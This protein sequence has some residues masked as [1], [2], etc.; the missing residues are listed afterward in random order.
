MKSDRTGAIFKPLA[1]IRFMINLAEHGGK[2][3]VL[4][5]RMR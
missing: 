3:A 1:S 2:G 4:G 5:F